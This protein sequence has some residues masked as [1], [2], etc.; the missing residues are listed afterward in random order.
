M[1]KVHGSLT[2]AGKVRLQTPK[3]TPTEKPKNRIGRSKKR[4]LYNIR[5]VGQ[6]HGSNKL[7]PNCLLVQQKKLKIKTEFMERL[8]ENKKN[9]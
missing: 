9:N 1:G 5:F 2:R 6:I 4:R 3:V 7:K 8:A